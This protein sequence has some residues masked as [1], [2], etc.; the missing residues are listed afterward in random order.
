MKQFFFLLILFPIAFLAKAQTPQ[1]SKMEVAL[2][3]HFGENTIWPNEENLSNFNIGYLGNNTEKLE[4]L[5]QLSKQQEVKKKKINIQHYQQL[6]QLDFRKIQLLYIDKEF[7]NL[8]KTIFKDLGDLPVLLVTEEYE[9]KKLVMINFYQSEDNRIKFEINNSNIIIQNLNIKPQLMFYGGT[10]I[11][12]ASIYKEARTQMETALDSLEKEREKVGEMN[13]VIN[14]LIND[15]QV[16]E[17]KLLEQQELIKQRTQKI[18]AQSASIEEQQE[19]LEVIKKDIAKTKK[20]LATK[21]SEYQKKQKELRRKNDEL[22]Q[23][24]DKIK[25]YDQKI[26]EQLT[27]IEQQQQ[28]L[29]K[30]SEALDR[31]FNTIQKQKN[32]IILSGIF[33]VIVVILVALTFGAYRS[34]NK[35]YQQLEIQNI[36]IHDQTEELRSQRDELN[37]RNIKIEEQ[38]EDLESA[39]KDLKEAQTMLVHSEKMASLGLVTAGIAHE[40]NTPLGAINASVDNINDFYIKAATHIPEVLAV[41]DESTTQVFTGLIS[42]Y[43]PIEETVSTKEMRKIKRK[44]RL[45]LEEKGIENHEEI[46]FYLAEMHRYKNWESLNPILNNKHALFLL[47]YAHWFLQL[48]FNSNNIKLAVKKASK[49]LFALKKYSSQDQSENMVKTDLKENLEMVLTIYHNHLKYIELNLNFPSQDLFVMAYPD[50]LSQIWT[51]IIH[52][53]LQAMDYNGRLDI[54][55]EVEN[56]SYLIYFRDYG[57]GIPTEIQ[58]KVFKP[59]FSTKSAGEGSGLGLDIVKKIVD[60]HEGEI[61][62]ESEEGKGTTFYVRIST[63]LELS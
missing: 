43:Q 22:I 42:T 7:N 31:S 19:H 39:L 46:A 9:N 59:F 61:Y 21:N 14:N 53:G 17:E 40:I 34:K 57:K 12:I 5:K 23:K 63:E 3:Y 16:K 37:S 36:Q 20:D 48:K 29:N 38:K 58:D 60:R 44:L 27:Y 54:G 30:Q 50:E 1:V 33:I 4:Y 45:E 6:N 52:N 32:L 8:I 15:I 25:L 26:N 41:L 10:Q 35:A 28:D 55:V 47:E 62:F 24:Q 18:N 56:S 13:T 51:N 2:L 11:D 49:V